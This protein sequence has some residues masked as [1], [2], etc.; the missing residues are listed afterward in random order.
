MN[1]SFRSTAAVV[2]IIAGLVVAGQAGPASAAPARSATTHSIQLTAAHP[3]A[4][5]VK[6]AAAARARAA[7]AAKAKAVAAAKAKAAAQARAKAAAA[8]KA[9]AAAAAKAKAEAAAKAAAA[10]KAKAAAA[11]AAKAKAAA[12]AAAAAKAAAEKTAAA[13][14]VTPVS[15]TNLLTPT[16]PDAAMPVGDVVSNG[17]TWHQTY[18][19][20]FDTDAP[21]GTFTQKYP[22]MATYSGFKD[23]SGQGLYAPDKV[24]SVSN[25]NLD[26]YLHSE[27]DQPLVAAVMP[28]D[29]APHVTGR[30]SI[31]FKADSTLGYKFVGMF[32]P[33]DD[34]WN[35][36]EIDWPE[37]DL[38]ATPRPASAMPGTFANGSMHF[39]PATEM[40]ADSN[41]TG[42][43]V[44][45]TEWDK[46]A[47]R[48]YW[49]GQLVSTVTN[50][51]PTTA[52]RVTLQAETF[53]GEGTVPKNTSGH[54]DIDWISIWD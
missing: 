30:V 29:Y 1:V 32:W 49:D 21:L 51:V 25:G 12:A 47:V 2:A 19:Q 10:A 17:R 28:D 31:R 22:T 39:M 26:F 41:T 7:A 34:N 36:G 54:L 43:H 15:A 8:A 33:E 5:Q 52:M 6:A 24:L 4:A 37:A 16:T 53:I 35:E 48:F 13:K 20:N 3:T 45:T 44:A 50:A 40:F 9:K 11:A 23:T 38:G 42:Y 46:N 18:A 14:Q 27:N